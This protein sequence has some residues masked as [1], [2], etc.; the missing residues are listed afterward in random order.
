M[1]QILRLE[2]SAELKTK[3]PKRPTRKT[4]DSFMLYGS[5]AVIVVMIVVAIAAPVLTW[6]NPNTQD[7]YAVLLG[8][9]RSHPFGT[10]ELGRDLFART[11]Y[12]GRASIIAGLEGMLV[13]VTLGVPLGVAGGLFGGKVDAAVVRIMDALMSFPPII[14]AMVI[15]TS[16]GVSLHTAMIAVGVV[17]A[18]RIG[19]VARVAA[20]SVATES[21]IEA[22]KIAGANWRWTIIR[23]VMPNIAGPLMVQATLMVA[24]S[25][26]AESSLSFLGLGIQ[27]PDTSWGLLLGRG[28]I[29]MSVNP[30]YV[31]A[32][33][34]AIAVLVLAINNFGDALHRSMQGTRVSEI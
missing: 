13:A 9:S 6:H 11:L 34:L 28:Y 24:L 20:K 19:R 23:H 2:P 31:I 3:S 4:T 21:Y 10:D 1:A 18:P 32:P 22:A 8:P 7:L 12:G 25:I 15:V 27:P 14:L 17:Y 29:H 26:L 5:L 33:G 30:I 16:I